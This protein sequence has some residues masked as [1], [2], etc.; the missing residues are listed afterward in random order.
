MKLHQSLRLGWDDYLLIVGCVRGTTTTLLSPSDSNLLLAAV[1]WAL[2][3]STI[4]FYV[5]KS[6]S[7]ISTNGLEF[8]IKLGVLAVPFWCISVTGIKV[9]LTIQLLRFQTHRLWR[10]F[11]YFIIGFTVATYT[12]FGLFDLLQCFPLEATWNLSITNKKCVGNSIYQ[13]VSNAQSGV[14]ISTDII[15]SLFP[16]TF[17]RHLRR[18]RTEKVLIGVLMAMGMMASAASITKAVLV[19][20]W[21]NATDSFKFRFAISMWTCVEMF[22]GIIAACLPSLK[23]TFQKLLVKMGMD[24]TARGSHSFFKSFSTRGKGVEMQPAE[25]FKFSTMDSGSGSGS[26]SGEAGR[27]NPMYSENGNESG[28]L[29]NTGTGRQGAWEE[30]SEEGR[31]RV[32]QPV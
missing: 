5:P 14:S 4:A 19:H 1:D 16:L 12:A 32:T 22:I 13:K 28:T 15:L 27:F 18:P 11:L 24:F 17:L 7:L 30:V 9:G 10:L 6:R 8:T 20:Q 21:A 2:L 3:L 26:G 29:E 31:T 23:S 25:S